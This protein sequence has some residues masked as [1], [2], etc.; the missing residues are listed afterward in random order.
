MPMEG[1]ARR[2]QNEVIL[3]CFAG[4]VL[5]PEGRGTKGGDMGPRVGYM[6][7]GEGGGR[8]VGGGVGG[9]GGVKVAG[10]WETPRAEGGGVSPRAWTTPGGRCLKRAV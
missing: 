4:W 2:F 5:L 6:G 1:L 10:S 9:R 3:D 7:W 8:G